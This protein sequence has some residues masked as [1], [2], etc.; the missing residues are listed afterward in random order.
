MSKEK[1]VTKQEDKEV[2]ITKETKVAKAKTKK[3]SKKIP[4][5]KLPGIYKKK[6]TEKKINKKLYSKIYVPEDKKYVQSLF[7]E[8]EKKGKKNIPIYAIPRDLTFTKKQITRL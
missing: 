7:V 3:E 5:K 4:T 2:A 8:C 1:D 6:Y